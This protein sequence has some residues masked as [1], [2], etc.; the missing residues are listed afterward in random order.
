MIKKIISFIVI[1]V[2]ISMMAFIGFAKD[3]FSILFDKENTYVMEEACAID[4]SG[5]SYIIKTERE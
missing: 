2:S 4:R 5:N 1:I 3:T